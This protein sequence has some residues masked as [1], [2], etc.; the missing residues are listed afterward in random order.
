MSRRRPSRLFD[1]LLRPL[2]WGNHVGTGPEN[3]GDRPR[4]PRWPT[5]QLSAYA[6]VRK[7]LTHDHVDL[8]REA[9]ALLCQQI[10]EAEVSAQIGA[11]SA[12]ALR[13]SDATPTPVRAAGCRLSHSSGSSMAMLFMRDWRSRLP[14]TSPGSGRGSSGPSPIRSSCSLS[15]ARY[16]WF[17]SRPRERAT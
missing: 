2:G 5:P 15:A 4:P 14:A 1:A 8:V 3:L 7:V 13:R 11:G 17:A 12:S 9:V 10:M 6:L 16:T